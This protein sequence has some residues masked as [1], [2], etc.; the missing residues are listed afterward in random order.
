M[1]RKRFLLGGYD[2]KSC[3]EKVRK[4][5]DPAYAGIELDP[6]TSGAQQR[7][8]SGVLRETVVGELWLAA[9]GS[10]KFRA[11]DACDRSEAS[12]ARREAQ[13]VALMREPGAVQV[14]WNAR[15]PQQVES[16]RT[17]EPDALVRGTDRDGKPTWFPVDV[18]DHRSLE[19]TSKAKAIPVSEMG[20]PSPR[21]ASDTVLGAGVPQKSDALQLAHYY[22]MLDELGF[23][24]DRKVGGIIGREG[25]IVWHDLDAAIY[26]HDDLGKVGALAY[27]D[28]E[29][30]HRVDIAAKALKGIAVTGPEWKG[31]CSDCPF[32]T[33]CHDELRLD[34]DHITLL[35]G[36]TAR[37][38]QAHYSAGVTRVD[39]LARLDWRTARLVDLGVDVPSVM[40]TAKAAESDTPAMQLAPKAADLLPKLGLHNAAD[41]A[42]LDPKTASYA[43]SG[44]WNL[45][46]SID[47]ARVTKVGK[48]HLQRDIDFVGLLPS[49]IEQDVDIEDC[50]GHVYLIGVR[51][52]GRKK[53]G[54][55]WKVRSEYNAF[56][57]WSHTSEGEARVFAEFWAH[58]Q[59]WREKAKANK[60]GY[61][62]YHYTKHENA[63]F[64]AL[65]ERHAGKEGVPTVEELKTFLDS[66]EWTDLHR[67]VST[68]LIW[69]TES[70][71]LK[72]IAKWV[73]FSWRD[74]DPGGGN[75]IAWYKTAIGSED[76]TVRSENRDRL[77][78]Y[79][80]DDCQAQ[81]EVRDWLNRL[82]EARQPGKRLPNVAALDKRF[83]RR[84][85]SLVTQ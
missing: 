63:A 35:P 67:V 69:P 6:P 32:R 70:V 42:K 40:V 2:A 9:L 71:T 29:F 41:L 68:Q 45:A 36:I 43:G 11:V 19:G 30:A 5:H 56:V 73:R 44:V 10:R 85:R 12:K 38:A 18:K 15:L 1:P 3:P 25:V 79:N 31:E 47:Q 50:D 52:V 46:G 49:T 24:T 78:K 62:A 53:E 8:E 66:K 77:L 64:V 26:N 51:T 81:A 59:G 82:G 34:L 14:I 83:A 21:H 16:H 54:E 61:R 60:W 84:T 13:T 37:R 17:G 28:H 58:V 27:Y 72:D 22:R 39:E 57:D 23:A 65:A 33:V 74:S 76:E 48:V 75:S 7:M 80:A 4:S 20:K 55:D